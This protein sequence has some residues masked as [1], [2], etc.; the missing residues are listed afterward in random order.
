MADFLVSPSEQY[1]NHSLIRFPAKLRPDPEP[2]PPFD[3]DLQMAWGDPE[4]AE[5]LSIELSELIQ[6]SPMPTKGLVCFGSEMSDT[7]IASLAEKLQVIG[8]IFYA[9]TRIWTPVY[10]SGDGQLDPPLPLALVAGMIA[11]PQTIKETLSILKPGNFFTVTSL[12]SISD[13]ESPQID[14]SLQEAGII[15]RHALTGNSSIIQCPNFRQRFGQDAFE[16]ACTANLHFLGL[17]TE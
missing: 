15:N 8:T 7:F 3:L 1:P 9:S 4:V 17:N 5:K 2:T 6:R 10:T 14:L 12:F 16:K 13:P 11:N